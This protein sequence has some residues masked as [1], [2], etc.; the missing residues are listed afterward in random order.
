[1]LSIDPTDATARQNLKKLRKN[2]FAAL[3]KLLMGSITAL[4]TPSTKRP[5]P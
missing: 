5:A 3:R 2:P 4:T 1:V